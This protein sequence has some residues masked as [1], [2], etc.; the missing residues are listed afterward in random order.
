MKKLLMKNVIIIV[1]VFCL[2][3]VGKT[4]CKATGP[5][6]TDD[7][8]EIEFYLPETI[9]EGKEHQILMFSPQN[10]YIYANVNKETKEQPKCFINNKKSEVIVNYGDESLKV[11][12]LAGGRD[13]LQII[14]EEKYNIFKTDKVRSY[15]TLKGYLSYPSEKLEIFSNIAVTNKH[16]GNGSI[17]TIIDINDSTGIRIG[18]FDIRNYVKINIYEE[19][20]NLLMHLYMPI[21]YTSDIIVNSYKDQNIDVYKSIIWNNSAISTKISSI[22]PSSLRTKLNNAYKV[23]STDKQ[24]FLEGFVIDGF[25]KC[26]DGNFNPENTTVLSEIASRKGSELNKESKFTEY[27]RIS[28][29]AAETTYTFDANGGEYESDVV[30]IIKTSYNERITFPEKSPTREGYNFLGYFTESTNG[31][32]VYTTDVCSNKT[33]TN[34]TLYAHWEEK[35]KYEIEVTYNG[36]KKTLVKKY[37][38]TDSI[39][40]FSEIDSLFSID[41]KLE[42]TYKIGTGIYIRRA[43]KDKSINVNSIKGKAD[44]TNKI[45]I[46][47]TTKNPNEHTLIVYITAFDYITIV[48]EKTST[49]YSLDTLLSSYRTRISEGCANSLSYVLVSDVDFNNGNYNNLTTTWD[50]SANLNLYVKYDVKAENGVYDVTSLKETSSTAGKA[51]ISSIPATL[52]FTIT[53]GSTYGGIKNVTYKFPASSSVPG[54]TAFE[55]RTTVSSSAIVGQNN[56][57]KNYYKIVVY[58]RYDYFLAPAKV[59]NARNE[60]VMKR[61]I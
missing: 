5:V 22:T 55:Y 38:D 26:N 35:P 9:S 29:H 3:T 13:F 48:K 53:V 61:N 52:N 57:Y 33:D 42:A 14:N 46:E 49:P 27:Y 8:T 23:G 16:Y 20:N 37:Y 51:T 43:D 50:A 1:M 17:N 12:S 11:T 25:I 7:T 21:D 32:Q 4:E 19:T 60:T 45:K 2:F 24:E 54:M 56:E 47:L 59:D 30:T 58:D 39:N 40:C 34:Q 6:I 18:S 41:K 15:G 28:G 31:T 36:T 44:E 10:Y